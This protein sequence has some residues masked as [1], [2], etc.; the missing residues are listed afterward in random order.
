M[1]INGLAQMALVL[2]VVLALAGPV[3]RYIAAILGGERTF[4]SPVLVPVERCTYAILGIDPA[5]G[6]GWRSYVSAVLL[7]NAVHFALLYVILRVQ[8]YLPFNPQGI[9]GMPPGLA[10]N[11]AASFVTNTNWQAYTPESGISNGAQML[12]LTVHMFVSAATGVAIAAAVIRA[13]AAGGVKTLGNAWADITRAMLY[14]LLP[15]VIVFT[16]ILMASGVPQTMLGYAQVTTLEGAKQTIARGPVAFQEAIKL[17]GTNGGG[18]FNANSAHPFENPTALTC[19]IETIMLLMIPFAL[20]ATFG[21]MVGNPAQGRALL[22]AMG[23]ILGFGALGCY[24]AEMSGT[25]MLHGFGVNQ[26]L[27]NME[28]RE[29]RFGNALTTLL[30]VGATGTSTG[31]VA[32]FTDSFTPLGGLIPL[33]L[34]QLGEV[35][36]GGIGSGL[37]F[38]VVFALLSVFVAGLMAGRTPEYLGKKVQA[39]EVKLAMLAFLILTAWILSGASVS[40]LLPAGVAALANAGPHGLTEMLYAWTSATQNNGSAMAGITATGPLLAYGQAFAMLFGRFAVLVPVMA[41]AGSLAAKPK[42]QA[43]SGT[44]PTTGPLFIG[45][46]IGVIIILGGLQFMPADALGPL[47]EHFAMRAG[48]TY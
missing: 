33:F 21:R 4:L 47:A 5:K 35:T 28:G 17:L 32:G 1:T 36:P 38:M 48:A 40:L 27:G 37:Y 29:L 8:Y 24:A 22:W 18:F 31:A 44:F 15:L 30:N 16:I 7:M 6:M 23:L 25:T 45:L 46:L 41:I 43:T 3:G 9:A 13:F 39:R 12:G 34:M 10:F 19:A 11:T 14:L 42:L 20:T 26:A 2:A